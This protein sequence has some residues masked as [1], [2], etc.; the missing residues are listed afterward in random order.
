M[1]FIRHI[2]DELIILHQ[3]NMQLL[4]HTVHTVQP[5]TLMTDD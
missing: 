2:I 4:S 5:A 3:T 1:M